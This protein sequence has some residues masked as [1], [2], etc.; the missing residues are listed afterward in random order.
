MPDQPETRLPVIPDVT[1]K[2]IHKQYPQLTE[3]RIT[4]AIEHGRLKARQES[5]GAKWFTT[6]AWVQEWVDS[7]VAS[8]VKAERSR[9]LRKPER[10]HKPEQRTFTGKRQIKYDYD[11]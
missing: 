10:R 6:W 4:R 8:E 2:Q 3:D 9:Q 7:W 11:R 5:R 1:I